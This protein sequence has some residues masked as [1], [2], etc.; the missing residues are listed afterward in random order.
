[1]S[2][3]SSEIIDNM[4]IELECSNDMYER[5]TLYFQTDNIE[6]KYDIEHSPQNIEIVYDDQKNEQIGN[7]FIEPRIDDYSRC[8]GNITQC[9]A[10][11]RIIH[12]LKYYKHAQE[13][14]NGETVFLYEYIASLNEYNM[15]VF[16]EDWHHS[17]TRHFNS[18]SDHDY[19]WLKNDQNI[20][21]HSSKGTSCS[22]IK[23][24]QRHR[25]RVIYNIKQTIDCNNLILQ[26]KIDS[27]HAF[28]FHPFPS[29]YHNILLS[30]DE[31]HKDIDETLW[32]NN[33]K[34]TADCNLSQILHILKDGIIFNQV[35]KLQVHEK[36]IFNYIK[37][38]CWDGIK[39]NEI[40]RKT[41]LTTL[42]NHLK[43][44][45]LKASLGKL[46]KSLFP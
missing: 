1:M 3:K 18:E 21:C 42:A 39:L 37:D 22:H 30:D 32:N 41:F 28:I 16:M 27:I 44:K 14:G 15:S 31:K 43:N 4:Q 26:E 33:P 25:G 34:C 45:K 12:L 20:N 17:K 36:D 6:Q 46:Y 7:D 35:E 9:H 2:N 11:Q 29:I 40:K 23:R 19:K 13:N 10:M 38:N 24:H 5:N 8:S